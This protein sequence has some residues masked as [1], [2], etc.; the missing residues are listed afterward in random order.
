MPVIGRTINV[1]MRPKNINVTEPVAQY[2]SLE[3]SGL[4]KL[5]IE[6]IVAA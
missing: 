1:M 4:E 6:T 3:P 5:F 2:V